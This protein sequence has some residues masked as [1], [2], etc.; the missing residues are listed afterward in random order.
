MNEAEYKGKVARGI[1]WIGLASTLVGALDIVALVVVLKFWVSRSDYG[2]AAAVITLFPILDLATDMGLSSAVI[3]K[4]DHTPEVISTVWWLNLGMSFVLFGLLAIVAPILAHVQGQPIIQW[5]LI[6]YGGKLIFQNVYT[7]PGAMMKR[8]LRFKELSIIRVIANV[9]EFCGKI[10]FAWMGLSIWCF[11]LGPLV[12]VLI[13]GIGIQLRHPWWPKRVLKLRDAGDY[14]K[15]GMKTSASQ[16]LFYFYT[17]I[18]YQVVLYY[19]GPAANGLYKMAYELVLEPVR[20][21]SN[22]VVDVAFP[23]FSRLRNKRALLVEQFVAFTRQNLVIVMPYLALVVLIAEEMLHV[24]FGPEWVAAAGA[25]R[26]LCIVGIFR[27]LSYVVP[28]LLDGIGYPTTTLKYTL[29]ASVVLPGLYIVCAW[30]LGDRYGYVSVAIAWAIGYPIAF[31]V[32]AFLALHRIGLYG[33]EYLRR[34]MGIPACVAGATLVGWIARYFTDGMKPGPRLAIVGGAMGVVLIVL[35]DYFQGIS[36]RKLFRNMKS[37]Q[38]PPPAAP[39]P[40]A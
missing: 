28:P 21:I 40:V 29:T 15:Y 18:D 27:A 33:I 34:V 4:D 32:L 22:V 1:M 39:P 6:A 37:D 5:L 25:A 16:I 20:I 7:I 8:E 31:A 12:R 36:F 13:T 10:G 11:V 30:L 38:P 24:F 23:L 2:I 14:F 3:Q 9:G 17:N 35:L 19:F 26:I